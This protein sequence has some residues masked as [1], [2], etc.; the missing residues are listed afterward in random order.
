MRLAG[1]YH[2]IEYTIERLF[3]YFPSITLVNALWKS[4]DNKLYTYGNKN[5]I[6]S[7]H[8]RVEAQKLRNVS[9]VSV[10]SNHIDLFS[11]PKPSRQQLTIDEEDEMNVL[12]LHFTSPVDGLKDILLI[13]FPENF[14]LKNPNITFKKIST[15]EK[16]LI[17]KIMGATLFADY[18]KAIDEQMLLQQFQKINQKNLSKIER[19][20][21]EAKSTQKLYS[22]AI[23]SI[24]QE[25]KHKME[26][27]LNKEIHFADS[28]AFKLAKERLTIE[29]IYNVLSNA[30][31]LALNFNATESIINVNDDFLLLNKTQ[32]VISKETV[33]NEESRDKVYLLLDRYEEAAQNALSAGLTINGKNVAAKLDPPVTPPAITDAVKK[34]KI[35]IN[36]LLK[37]YPENW[38]LIR[39]SI[40]P[41][42]VLNASIEG[43]RFAS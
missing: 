12:Q 34:N 43:D 26:E 39:K 14:L 1:T 18:Q 30:I 37:E 11:S 8:L 6:L 24:I 3:T 13:R 40:R 22:N 31:Y 4:Y 20:T 36:Y 28:I 9:S 17:E 38:P 19:L 5:A 35:K 27:K 29:E 41:I 16:T 33:H 15:Q 23:H 21:E 10:W 42:A 32:K 2:P 7:D 25:F